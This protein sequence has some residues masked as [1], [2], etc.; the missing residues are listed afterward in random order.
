[1]GGVVFLEI[2]LEKVGEGEEWKEQI[3]ELAQKNAFL[4]VDVNFL[5]KILYV[6]DAVFLEDEAEWLKGLKDEQLRTWLSRRFEGK[7]WIVLTEDELYVEFTRG[8]VDKALRVVDAFIG[9]R[10]RGFFELPYVLK[11]A[12]SVEIAVT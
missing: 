9:S 2:P 5:D 6:H 1:V 7:M 10:V 11:D 12:K 8:N 3:R 4:A